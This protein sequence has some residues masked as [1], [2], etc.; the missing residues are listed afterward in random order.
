MIEIMPYDI[1]LYAHWIEL[2]LAPMLTCIVLYFNLLIFSLTGNRLAGRVLESMS[3]KKMKAL[4][5]Y[6]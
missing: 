6:R 4:N 5:E 1:A 2:W 3:K